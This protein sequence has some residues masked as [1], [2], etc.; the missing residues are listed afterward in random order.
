MTTRR[1]NTTTGNTKP[2]GR[3]ELVLG[4]LIAVAIAIVFWSLHKFLTLQPISGKS[5]GR[6]AREAFDAYGEGALAV[7]HVLWLTFASIGAAVAVGL[8][9]SYLI[10]NINK[11]KLGYTIGFVMAPV[12]ALINIAAIIILTNYAIHDVP[13]RNFQMESFENVQGI[14]YFFTYLLPVLVAAAAVYLEIRL[15]NSYK[16]TLKD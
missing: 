2:K 9:T 5:S 6:R 3:A 4:L 16:K 11:K 12:V 15:V 14:M 13:Y 1:A 7:D 8:I 10:F